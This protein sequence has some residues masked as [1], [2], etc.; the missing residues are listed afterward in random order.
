MDEKQKSRILIRLKE[1]LFNLESLLYSGRSKNPDITR[2]AIIRMNE[3][4]K[5]L[6]PEEAN[7]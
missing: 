6:T 3:R 7:D 4:I 1:N 2:E 5:R